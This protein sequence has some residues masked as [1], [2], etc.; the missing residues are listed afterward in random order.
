M[1]K[2]VAYS[3]T[4]TWALWRELA[5]LSPKPKHVPQLQVSTQQVSLPHLTPL[6]DL[7]TVSQ[8]ICFRL[9]LTIL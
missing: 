4:P 6:L 2:G 1:R 5:R 9:L 8:P 7:P 3:R